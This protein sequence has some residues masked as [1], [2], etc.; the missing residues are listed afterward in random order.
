MAWVQPSER[1]IG[2]GEVA[3]SQIEAPIFFLL[4]LAC[5]LTIATVHVVVQNNALTIALAMSLLVFGVTV[6]RVEYGL[7]VL[8]V[9]M[10]LSPEVEAGAVGAN[11]ERGLNLRYDDIL[12]VVIF[13]GVMVKHAF[14]GRPLLWRPNPINA[15]IFGY[16]AVAVFSSLLALRLSVPAWDRDVAFF[17]L[18][19]MFQFYLI[20]FMVGMAITSMDEIRR[21][22]RV[23]FGTSI[24]V[25]VYGIVSISTQPRVSAPFEAGGTE[26]NTFGGY[27]MIV[28]CVALA[29]AFFAP[30]ARTRY[31]LFGVAGIAIIPFLMTLSRASYASIFV[32]LVILGVMARQRWL[33][34]VLAMVVFAAPVLMPGKVL[35]RIESTFEPSGV[36][37]SIPLTGTEVTIDKSAYE[38]VY[39]WRKVRHNLRVWPWFGGGVSWDTVLDSQFARVIIETGVIG[40]ALFAFLLWRILKMTRQTYRWSRDWVA[41]ALGLS[42][43]AITI[44][45]IVHSFGTIT[46]LI[47]RIMEPYWFLMALAGVAR[48]IALLD[49]FQR[50]QAAQEE[51]SGTTSPEPVP[52]RA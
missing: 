38:R 30:K 37:V 35:K 33:L 9:A 24:I 5:T 32:T 12:I 39:V 46:F 42:L 48:K 27:L 44:G 51:A 40:L 52:Q 15:G 2:R 34:L 19:K 25:C 4:M 1:G 45:F 47:V 14:E 20:F 23:F 17:V 21:Q 26:P 16:F 10:L 36:A 43:F 29:L 41:R 3:E 18:L 28:I 22:L 7:Y 11:Q 6:V 50:Q 49:H 13:L 8:L 31:L